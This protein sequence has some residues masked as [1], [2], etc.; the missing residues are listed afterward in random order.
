MTDDPLGCAD[1]TFGEFQTQTQVMID[2][3]RSLPAFRVSD[4]QGQPIPARR[5]HVD[6]LLPAENVSLLTADG[7]VGKTTLCAQLSV[8]TSLGRPWL[9][10][11]CA[12]GG[13]ILLTAEE[14]LREL[15][16][17][18]NAVREAEDIAF[19]L[20]ANVL[21][22]PLAGEDAVLAVP[23]AAGMLQSTE[24]F[25]ALER[26]VA[27]ERPALVIIDPIADTFGGDENRKPQV[28]AFITLLRS[29]A[30]RYRTTVLLIGHP[31]Q[32]GMASG[33]GTSGN[34]AWNNS[35]RSRLYLNRITQKEGIEP[36]PDARLLTV[37]K[38]NFVQKGSSIAL[39]WRDGVFVVDGA[40][41]HVS[42]PIN[43]DRAELVFLDLLDRFTVEGRNVTALRS[44]SYAPSV[45]AKHID[46]AGITKDGFE[47]AM[48]RLLKAN[49]IVI[50]WSGPESKRRSRLAAAPS[51]DELAN[52]L[53]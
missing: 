6:G 28:R 44:S 33:A 40:S 3:R 34:T 39:R 30:I 36:D 43:G 4:F 41:R 53:F 21:V 45:F 24:R 42:T 26:L 49:R 38:A 17:L 7:A 50:E 9:G 32:S 13:V 5:W 46:A 8:S 29:L 23:G 37:K 31:S 47:L 19:S 16:R 48:D 22:I 15:K 27:E 1:V 12:Q 18:L 14:D 51:I 10:H 35:V 20:L 25:R 11:P 52:V 2:P